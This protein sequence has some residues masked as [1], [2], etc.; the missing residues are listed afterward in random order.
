MRGRDRLGPSLGW[1][2]V[3]TLLFLCLAEAG[4]HHLSPL[5]PRRR[6]SSGSPSAELQSTSISRGKLL[7]ACSSLASASGGLVFPAVAGRHSLIAWLKVG[8]VRG[9][10]IPE[11]LGAVTIGETV[12]ARPPPPRH[13]ADS[14]LKHTP[15]LSEEEP[16]LSGQELRPEWQGFAPACF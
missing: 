15:G 6:W 2:L 12:L 4:G 1:R 3:G 7:S 9:A 8:R 16:P 14:R 10:C 13:C 5:L 11:S